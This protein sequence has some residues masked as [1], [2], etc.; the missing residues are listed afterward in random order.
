MKTKASARYLTK[1]LF[2]FSLVS[3]AHGSVTVKHSSQVAQ[4]VGTKPCTLPGTSTQWMYAYCLA[5]EE[6]DDCDAPTTQ[7]CTR[8]A[9][10]V[11]SKLKQTDC[12]SKVYYQQQYC[13]ILDIT[14]KS[15]GGV[16]QKYSDCLKDTPKVVS[17]GCS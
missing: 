3:C 4:S 15:N 12:E 1:I 7:K 6:T 17:E 9:I 10:T 13:K 11:I 2:L 16:G 8:E 5:K 14:F